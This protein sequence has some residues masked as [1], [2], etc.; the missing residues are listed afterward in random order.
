MCTWQGLSDMVLKLPSPCYNGDYTINSKTISSCIF[1][2][3]IRNSF[4]N[5]PAIVNI[6]F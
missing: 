3:E 4:S 5:T 1:V 2:R 6:T